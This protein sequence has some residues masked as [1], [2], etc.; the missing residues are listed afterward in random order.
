VD[1]LKA[2]ASQVDHEIGEANRKTEEFAVGK[3]YDLHEIVIAS[4]KADL[5]F[6]LLLQIRNKLLD[7]YQ[8]VMRM[9]F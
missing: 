4:E 3:E 9:Q 6:R 5:S 1:T 2:F 8:E 7:A